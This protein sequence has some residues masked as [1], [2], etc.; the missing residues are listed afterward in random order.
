MGGVRKCEELRAGAAELLVRGTEESHRDI[1]SAEIG[2][3][4]SEPDQS[5]M[6]ER[7]IP[8]L[9]ERAQAFAK[10]TGGLDPASFGGGKLGQVKKAKS[11]ST[12]IAHCPKDRDRFVLGGSPT[13]EVALHV[14]GDAE[15]HEDPRDAVVVSDLSPDAQLFFVERECRVPACALVFH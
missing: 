15:H 11:L 7:S 14:R 10:S 2:S 9:D 5:V 6:N 1:A 12:P 8:D 13:R 4:S 3:H